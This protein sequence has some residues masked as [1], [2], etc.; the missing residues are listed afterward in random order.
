MAPQTAQESRAVVFDYVLQ[1][2]GRRLNWRGGWAGAVCALYY[3][4]H[5]CQRIGTRLWDVVRAELKGQTI[6]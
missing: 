4:Q 5:T 6:C 2:S 3:V 1:I